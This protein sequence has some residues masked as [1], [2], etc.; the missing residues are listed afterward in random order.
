MNWGN[1][2]SG[3]GLSPVRRQAITWTSVDLL[4]IG[5]LGNLNPNSN[6]F[7][8]E[9]AFKKVVYEMAALLPS[10]IWI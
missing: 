7:I 10:G 9:N 2:G 8:Q 5:P 1:I 3:K 4:L 6:I